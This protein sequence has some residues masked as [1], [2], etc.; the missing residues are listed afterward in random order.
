MSTSGVQI[1]EK[2]L[3][4]LEHQTDELDTIC[5]RLDTI[6]LW[7]GDILERALQIG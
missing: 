3:I 7:N 2:I 5:T 1:L 6:K 4:Q